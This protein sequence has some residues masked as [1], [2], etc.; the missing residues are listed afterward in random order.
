MPSTFVAGS[1]TYE[2]PRSTRFGAT[3]VIVLG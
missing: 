3:L 1:L 2:T